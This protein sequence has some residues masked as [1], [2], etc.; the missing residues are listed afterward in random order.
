MKRAVTAA[1]LTIAGVVPLWR[2]DASHDTSSD[3]VLAEPAAPVQGT[4]DPT[5]GSVPTP[6]S[7]GTDPGTTPG[8]AAPPAARVVAGPTISTKHG[9]VQVEVTF[10]GDRISAVRM[11]KQPDSGPTKN[12]VPKLIA[13][14]L[15]AQSADVDSVSGAT[16]TSDAY[17]NSLQAA[18]DEAA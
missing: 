13:S 1:V 11:L 18:I 14:T 3:T 5:A 9:N 6:G 7:V 15:Q 10:Q 8:A 4:Q 2:Y 16:T 12:A 17:K